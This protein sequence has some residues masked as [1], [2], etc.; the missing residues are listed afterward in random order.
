MLRSRLLAILYLFVVLSAVLAV[1]S[2]P[3]TLI[4]RR[5]FLQIGQAVDVGFWITSLL[6]LYL[7]G[8]RYDPAYTF[9]PPPKYVRPTPSLILAAIR[10]VFTDQPKR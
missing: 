8:R 2:V 10:R 6:V 4:W 9:L 3:F 5:R 7:V 1:A